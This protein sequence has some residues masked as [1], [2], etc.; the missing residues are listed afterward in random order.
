MLQWVSLSDLQF[1]L[2]KDMTWVV[3]D[4]DELIKGIALSTAVPVL[5]EDYQRIEHFIRPDTI[6]D[7]RNDRLTI[8][9]DTE[10]SRP[11]PAGIWIA[12]VRRRKCFERVRVDKAAAIAWLREQIGGG[13]EQPLQKPVEQILVKPVE[14]TLQKPRKATK[15]D[16]YDAHYANSTLPDKII[17]ERIG[18]CVRTIGR[19]RKSPRVRK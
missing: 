16:V 6:V 14:Q 2:M 19:W 13:A 15:R 3:Y 4:A 18:V 9:L 17:A 12:G 10:P 5:T 1:S 8:L 7:A 11:G